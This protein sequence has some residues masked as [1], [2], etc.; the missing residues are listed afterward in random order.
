MAAYRK[1]V[2][3][4]VYLCAGGLRK[5]ASL[6]CSAW[7]QIDDHNGGNGDDDRL[8]DKLLSVYLTG[9]DEEWPVG[10]VRKSEQ[11]APSVRRKHQ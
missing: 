8:K 6:F 11:A 2:Q 9:C 5:R 4:R 10:V 7:K 3:R 1:L